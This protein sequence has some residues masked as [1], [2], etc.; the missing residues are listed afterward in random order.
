MSLIFC[1]MAGGIP[2]AE[3]AFK[4]A[5]AKN[6]PYGRKGTHEAGTFDDDDTQYPFH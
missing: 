1:A 6:F 3:A 5:T 2:T 4:E